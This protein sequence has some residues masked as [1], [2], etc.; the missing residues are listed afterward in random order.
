VPDKSATC[1]AETT[2]GEPEAQGLAAL[3][4]LSSLASGSTSSSASSCSPCPGGNVSSAGDLPSLRFFAGA[5]RPS[6]PEPSTLEP[7]L[8]PLP[9]LA[10]L[11][12]SLLPALRFRLRPAARPYRASS[13]REQVCFLLLLR[14]HAVQTSADEASAGGRCFSPSKS[15]TASPLQLEATSMASSIASSIKLNISAPRLR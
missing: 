1:T 2:V 13:E 15:V 11:P 10:L 8:P 14:M 12:L 6:T 4:R 5:S 9:P 7:S 3:S